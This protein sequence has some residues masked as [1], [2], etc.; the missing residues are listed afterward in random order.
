MLTAF[1]MQKFMITTVDDLL[2]FL[3]G[4]AEWIVFGFMSLALLVGI[5]GW[6]C[7]AFRAEY[8]TFKK[9]SKQVRNEDNLDAFD[10]MPAEIKNQWY[11]FDNS[12]SKNACEYLTKKICVKDTFKKSVAARFPAAFMKF[13]V[14]DAVLLMM[15]YYS[16]SVYAGTAKVVG[17]L[18]FGG[19]VL[20]VGYI[21][22][23]IF[24][25]VKKGASKRLAREYYE[26]I[27]YLNENLSFD[28]ECDCDCDE[29]VEEIIEGAGAVEVVKAKETPVVAE[30]PKDK[31][32]E[33]IAKVY[34]FE[35]NGASEEK[36][37]EVSV[38]LLAAKRNPH[39]ADEVTQAKINAA[40]KVLLTLI[41]K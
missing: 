18:I 41:N 29:C 3:K 5:V 40:M 21:W 30:S 33:I 35:A 28:S 38:L 39:N 23:L 24:L 20:A 32:D 16:Q 11:A 12:E 8:K 25:W 9:A 2:Y 15:L 14:L 1:N 37:R 19:S 31:T 4:N 34:Q 10:Q 36:L 22:Y 13:I 6:V 7:M 27:D 26:L 17:T